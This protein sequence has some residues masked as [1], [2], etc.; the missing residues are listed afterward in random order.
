MKLDE[1]SY[2][3]LQSLAMM[4][5]IINATDTLLSVHYT[6]VSLFITALPSCGTS[7]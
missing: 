7:T 1:T 3:K 5:M 4:I 6:C 2:C